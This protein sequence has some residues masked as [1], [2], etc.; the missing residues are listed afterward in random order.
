MTRQIF[1]IRHAKSSWANPMQSDFDRPLNERGEHDAPIMA[2]RLKDL[3][4]MPDLII[5]SAAKRTRQ[6][7]RRIAKE[8][9]YDKEKI[10]LQE[11]IYHC[12]SEMLNR[13]IREIDKDVNTAFI[14]AHNPGITSFVNNLSDLF[15]IDNMPTCGIVGAKFEAVSWEDFSTA[16]KVFI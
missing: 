2:K 10:D 1:L 3:N 12:E 6:T 7:A 5:A 11:R 13:V 15:N 16:K 4:V 9:G 8:L 14:V